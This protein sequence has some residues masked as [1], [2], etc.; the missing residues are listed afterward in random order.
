MQSNYVS[1]VTAKRVCKSAGRWHQG[2]YNIPYEQSQLIVS[3]IDTS[4][5]VF[6]IPNVSPLQVIIVLAASY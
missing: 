1:I 3:Y 2:R 5:V 4:N 6:L